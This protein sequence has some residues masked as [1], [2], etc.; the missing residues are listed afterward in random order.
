MSIR[1]RMIA[2]VLLFVV[3]AGCAP[4]SVFYRPGADGARTQS[5]TD[6]CQV[7]ALRDAPVAN[8]IRQ[9]PPIYYPGTTFCDPNG[10]C[11]VS[12][13]YWV[14]GGFET[15]DINAP[16]RA[17]LTTDCMAKR[18][19]QLISLPRCDRAIAESQPPIPNEV[20]PPV[21]QASCIMV[22][23]YGRW[24]IVTPGA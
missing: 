1:T 17:R 16:L 15:I 19:Y 23:P 21:T 9:L 20:L 10:R 13:G 6:Q 14:D 7:K 18:G 5:E 3:L 11:V 24:R 8:Q 12:P 2:C 22:L 4:V